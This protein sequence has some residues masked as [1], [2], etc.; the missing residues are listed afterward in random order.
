LAFNYYYYLDDNARASLYYMIAAFHDDVPL[1]A[2]SMPAILMGRD[3]NNKTSAALRYSRLQSTY[4]D[5]DTNDHPHD[6]RRNLED[7]I[8]KSMQESVKELSLYILTQAMQSAQADGRSET[9]LHDALCLQN[10]GYNQTIITSIQQK[11][12]SDQITCEILNLGVQSG[13]IT[14]DGKLI[15]PDA[16][17]NIRYLRDAER[18]LW[19]SKVF[20]G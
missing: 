5:Y 16:K 2:V 19:E 13:R 7:I 9:C 14:T 17:D 20:H 4:K 8:T 11:C 3:G 1:I 10:A 18:K 6:Q 15:N 12:S